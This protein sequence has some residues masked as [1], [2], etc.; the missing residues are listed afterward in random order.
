M[1][2]TELTQDRWA[3]PARNRRKRLTIDIDVDLHEDLKVAATRRKTSIR[4]Y[5]LEAVARE[6]GE[7]RQEAS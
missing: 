2:L 7:V 3:P 6:M 4:E 5:V 1:E